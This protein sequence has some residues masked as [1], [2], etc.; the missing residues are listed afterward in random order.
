[1]DLEADVWADPGRAADGVLH[2][3]AVTTLSTWSPPTPEAAVARERTLGLLRAGPVV[4]SRDH[5]PGHVT[6]SAVVVDAARR[7]VLLC[8][9]ARF[10]RWMQLGGHCEPADA[11]LAATALREATEESGIAG[12][13][14]HP[15]PID[16]DVHPV[17]CAG[18]PS[19]HYDVRFV[20][21]APAGT[22]ARA[23]P[24]SEEL[25]WFGPDDL[26]EPMAHATAHLVAPALAAARALTATH[27]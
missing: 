24:E 18:G 13:V 6:A 14:L 3:D 17:T 22:V 15:E 12:L 11:T 20:A 26:P 27:R 10:R 25:G 8:L 1:M 19:H 5:R 23:N 4:M 21:V 2:A 7:R 16:V 9:H